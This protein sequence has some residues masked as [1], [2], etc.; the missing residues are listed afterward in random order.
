[1]GR[2]VSF[3]I[4]VS[5]R[6]EKGNAVSSGLEAAQAGKREIILNISSHFYAVIS[7]NII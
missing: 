7:H 6:K 2:F 4:D 5:L 3:I 1:M